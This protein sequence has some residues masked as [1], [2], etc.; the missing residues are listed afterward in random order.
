MSCQADTQLPFSAVN[1]FLDPIVW[2]T[3]SFPAAFCCHCYPMT[4][5]CKY[6]SLFC[7]VPQ[8]SYS[9]TNTTLPLRMQPPSPT[10]NRV[11]PPLLFF[12]KIILAFYGPCNFSIICQEFYS[13]QWTLISTQEHSLKSQQ[14]NTGRLCSGTESNTGQCLLSTWSTRPPNLQQQWVRAGWGHQRPTVSTQNTH[15]SFWAP[16]TGQNWPHGP[17][18]TA[19]EAEM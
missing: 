2:A 17:H 9:R 16:P 19:R 10:A 5:P 12:F 8:F 11:R 3:W 7:L 15:T 6:D 1:T 18:L 4:V 14:F 13:A